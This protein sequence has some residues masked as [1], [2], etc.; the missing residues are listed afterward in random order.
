M[1]RETDRL[2]RLVNELLVLTRADAGALQ[3]NFQTIDLAE[4]AAARCA[5]FCNWLPDKAWKLECRPDCPS[6]GCYATNPPHL[7]S[8]TLIGWPSD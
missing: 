4:L 8:Q 2:I 1:Q 3:L 5:V 6:S 7:C